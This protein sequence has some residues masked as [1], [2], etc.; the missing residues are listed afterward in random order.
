M[1]TIIVIKERKSNPWGRRKG[2]ATGQTFISRVLIFCLVILRRGPLNSTPQLRARERRPVVEARS[3]AQTICGW[4][5]PPRLQV[6]SAMMCS[7]L[8]IQQ[9]DEA[10]DSSS[11]CSTRSV[12]WLTNTRN[13]I[14][15][16][17]SFTSRRLRIH[18]RNRRCWLRSSVAVLT[19]TEYTANLNSAILPNP[20]KYLE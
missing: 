4:T 12:A 18:A 9:T 10:I 5:R 14:F 2:G 3:L 20:C 16:A 17:G 19:A 13:Q 8:T 6:V 7:W 11:G 1:T 15:P